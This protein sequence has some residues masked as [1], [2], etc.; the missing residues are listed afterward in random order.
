MKSKYVYVTDLNVCKPGSAISHGWKKNCW[1]AVDYETAYG[2]KGQMLMAN[3]H[4]SAPT[5]R[6]PLKVKGWYRIYVVIGCTAL[7]PGSPP[8]VKV[9]L[10]SDPAYTVFTGYGRRWWMEFSEFLWKEADLTGEY[11]HI[12]K[13][14]GLHNGCSLPI[15]SYLAYFRLEPLT[16][17]EVVRI[18]MERQ[19][20]NSVRLIGTEDGFST[21]AVNCPTTKEELYENVLPY[22]DSDI[23]TVWYN[24]AD[25]DN[26]LYPDTSV[27]TSPKL[28]AVEK[29]PRELD[30][31][32]VR[33][34]DVLRKKRIDPLGTTCDFAHSLGLEFYATVRT[35]S[36]FCEAPFDEKFV[37]D[38]YRNHPE[39]RCRDR[40]GREI[41]RLSYAYPEVQQ[42]M[43]DMYLEIAQRNIDGFGWIFVRSM[44]FVFYEKPLIDS[45][46]NRYG[47]D[48]RQLAEDDEAVCSYRASIINDFIRKARYKLND[49]RAKQGRQ[50]LKFSAL[51]PAKEEI[52]RRCGLDLLTW[53]REG[54]ID[55][56]AVDWSLQD[57]N[58]PK[59]EAPDNIELDYFLNVVK[60]TKCLLS[61]RFGEI[62]K[63]E[64]TRLA[65]AYARG[66]KSGLIWDSRTYAQHF[67]H[68]WTFIRRFGHKNY[69][70]EW[71]DKG[72]TPER[73]Y[74]K[75]KT[76]GGSAMDKYPGNLAF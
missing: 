3:S 6:Y 23:K 60:G 24:A 32:F 40:D 33:T 37:S 35:G 62:D 59:N 10:T 55:I 67:P 52:N 20:V 71:V 19:D 21:I 56:L 75:L 43:L 64:F 12:A 57:R 49:L 36:F 34:M 46:I 18:E 65:D 74:I 68:F 58:S 70:R 66:V 16:K 53:A 15:E 42:H 63:R 1:R 25:G 76:L 11:F 38:F 7:L 39:Y 41:P 17:D 31:G 5:V 27:G 50:P 29:Y 28:Q 69:I 30:L 45:F 72:I 13:P 14:N 4:I 51:V 48:P 22:A 8:T 61:P 44:P 73:T 54:L 47:N 2:L 26:V 9:K